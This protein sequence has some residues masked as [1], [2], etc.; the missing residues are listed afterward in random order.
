MIEE[1][2]GL[3]AVVTTHSVAMAPTLPGHQ[4]AVY[5]HPIP[6]MEQR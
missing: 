3:P 6:E 5:R 4:K 2:S 1:E